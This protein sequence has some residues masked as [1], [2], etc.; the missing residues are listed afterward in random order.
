MWLDHCMLVDRSDLFVLTQYYFLYRSQPNRIKINRT[1]PTRPLLVTTLSN[2][3]VEEHRLPKVEELFEKLDH[4]KL[5]VPKQPLKSILNNPLP[6]APQQGILKKPK[7]R[8]HPDS[9]TVH[10]EPRMMSPERR[11]RQRAS[12]ESDN[13]Y[14]SFHFAILGSDK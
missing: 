6:K 1:S 9:G 4:E 10:R 11:R 3:K 13:L 2:T 5:E 7:H 14:S 8:P 12:S